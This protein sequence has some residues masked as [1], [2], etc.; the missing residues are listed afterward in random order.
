MTEVSTTPTLCADDHAAYDAKADKQYHDLRTGLNT[1]IATHAQELS[2]QIAN[3]ETDDILRL[4]RIGGDV[5]GQFLAGIDESI[6]Q[7]Y[8]C[9]TCKQ[10]FNGYGS[11]A[12]LTKDLK[13]IPLA[14]P[15]DESVWLP[16]TGE[17]FEQAYR[18]VLAVFD[19]KSVSPMTVAMHAEMGDYLGTSER[20]G[21]NHICHTD[22]VGIRAF[23]EGLLIDTVS[24]GHGFGQPEM[25][26]IHDAFRK[27][28]ELVVEKAFAIPRDRLRERDLY[29]LDLCVKMTKDYMSKNADQRTLW[30]TRYLMDLGLGIVHFKNSVVGALIEDLQKLS[31]EDALNNYYA[32]TDPVKYKRKVALPT[33]K[34]FEESVK[35]LEEN[36][37]TRK[38][39]MRFATP[40]EVLPIYK[41]VPP[42]K[43][44][45]VFAALR[46]KVKNEDDA[47][48]L[49]LPPE[50]ISISGFNGVLE[51]LI[52]KGEL[53]S[54]GYKSEILQYGI[55]ARNVAE[56]AGDAYVDGSILHPFYMSETAQ[57]RTGHIKF[58]SHQVHGIFTA[59]TSGGRKLYVLSF[60]GGEVNFGIRPLN[61]VET[62]NDEL[63]PH[64]RM[65]DAWDKTKY[66]N[67][68][69]S[70]GNP[71]AVQ[72][73]VILI[74]AVVNRHA[75]ISLITDTCVQD[76][77][78]TSER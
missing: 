30:V 38:L 15:T 14:F 29:E 18:N 45:D 22:V 56:D 16:L 8:N 34:Q 24:M 33:E 68:T 28:N 55:V 20:G 60:A 9:R 5:F 12:F 73:T 4:V 3:P 59:A 71:L 36:D 42:A 10:F 52:E 6:R 32:Y 41:W 66:L 43:T 76:F 11:L 44:V 13:V 26:Q 31:A 75:V 70:N 49:A 27:Y 69:D 51:E 58:D 1:I 39:E 47:K 7:Q 46:S 72:N 74:P 21:F 67:P 37:Y 61:Y 64:Q 62:L 19:V 2:K 53:K 48:R 63:K 25:V 54:I 57:M 77:I 50:Q 78:I 17:V 40:E 65:I 23:L 35:F